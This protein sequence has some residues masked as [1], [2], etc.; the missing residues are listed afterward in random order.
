MRVSDS[1]D[2]L[3]R[4]TAEIGG[5]KIRRSDD[6]EEILLRGRRAPR[7]LSCLPAFALSLFVILYQMV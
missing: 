5:E 7:R 6:S 4:R 3:K 1:E 2:S